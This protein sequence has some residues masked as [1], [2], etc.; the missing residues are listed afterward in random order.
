MMN[1]TTEVRDIRSPIERL[2][3]F[4]E[5]LAAQHFFGKITISF[6]NGKVCDVK[7]EQTKKLDEL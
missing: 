3:R 2:L 4:V 1:S 7:V 6:Q 5:K